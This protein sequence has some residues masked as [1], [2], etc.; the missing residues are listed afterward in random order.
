[1]QPETLQ[2]LRQ[3]VKLKL[4]QHLRFL[5]QERREEVLDEL[6]IASSPGFDYFF[7]VVLSCSIATFGLL[8][9]SAA[10]IIGAMLVAPLMSPI[11]GLSLASVA[12][13][14]RMFRNAVLALI[15]GV[16]L[17]ITLSTILG[18]VA[19]ALPF[20]ILVVIPQEILARTRP[21]PFDLGI[22]LAGGA[23]AAYALAQPRISAAL[24]GVAIATAL[25]PP[26]CTVG[27]GISLGD[28]GIA[29]GA[30]LLFFT[31]LA[32]IS[33]AGILVFA[34]LGF[35]P[36]H[37]ENARHHI[38]R[39]LMISAVMVLLTTIP[40]I[41]LTMRIVNQAHILQDARAAVVA[42]LES[43]YDAQLVDITLDNSNSTLHLDITVRTSQQPT[44]QQVVEL[45]KAVAERLQRTT[46]IQLIIIPTTKLDPLVPPTPTQTF[47]STLSPTPGPSQ[48]P[49][50]TSTP[51]ATHTPTSTS[52]PTITPTPTSTTT[53]TPTYTPTPVLAYVTTP[54]GSGVY[55][56]DTPGGKIIIWLP[57]NTPVSILYEK[58]TIDGREWIE[59]RNVL[60]QTGWVLVE[61]LV[62]R[63]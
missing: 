6:E 1:M 21:S 63:P 52:S 14:Q 19:Q 61:Y 9:D 39:S 29:L 62:I 11:L 30:S 12:S 20:D 41:I 33:F 55:L 47:T 2:G 27:I 44:Y 22:A 15:E 18:G 25:M 23:A 36:Q 50:F 53:L 51:T 26:L 42:E 8:T 4:V 34:A 13:E 28:S 17:A 54:G 16:I 60:N 45:Q 43:L 48:T 7:L 56:R 35:R 3:K 38:P 58:Q 5:P 32:A 59:I 40:L 10:V 57:E 31:N 24:P 46:A 37:L 49:T